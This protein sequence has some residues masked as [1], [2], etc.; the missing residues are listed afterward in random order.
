MNLHINYKTSKIIGKIFLYLVIVAGALTSLLPFLWMLSGSL[1]LDNELYEW[2][3]RWIP[4]ICRWSNFSEVL[5]TIPFLT[6]LFN[7]TKLSVIITFLQV[8]TCCLAAYAFS[9]IPFPGRDKLFVLYLATMMIPFQVTM[10]PQYIIMGKLGLRNT[11]LAIILIQ[12]F[13]PFG[14]FLLRQAFVGIPNELSEAARIDGCKELGILLRVIV[15]LC[16]A[17]IATLVT[18]T[19]TF[20]WNDYLGPMIYLNK[21]ELRTIQIGI[22]SFQTTNGVE[23]TLILAATVMSLAPLIIVYLC[24]QRYFIESAT[25][26]GVKG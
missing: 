21:E 8:V 2:P 24:C 3:I 17:S 20:V 6:Y 15:P 14:V 25:M 18:F 5:D 4:E 9:K 19:F 1:K 10:I 13:S 11:H 23:Y 26:S 22:K 16:K 7:T 12:A